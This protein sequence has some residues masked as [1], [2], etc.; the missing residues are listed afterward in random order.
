[1]FRSLHSNNT[2]TS[3]SICSL[4]DLNNYT[5]KTFFFNNFLYYI[6]CNQQKKLSTFNNQLKMFL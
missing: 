6:V 1:M 4:G 3:R 5:N 2:H